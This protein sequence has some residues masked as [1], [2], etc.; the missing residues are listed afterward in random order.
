M[1]C[2]W[3]ASHSPRLQHVTAP[4]KADHGMGSIPCTT[5]I[6]RVCQISKSHRLPVART[7][8]KRLN[9][10]LALNMLAFPGGALQELV[11]RTFRT[12]ARPPQIAAGVNDSS[13]S[14]QAMYTPESLQARNTK[15]VQGSRWR[16][17]TARELEAQ[18]IVV[19]VTRLIITA[20]SHCTFSASV[21]CCLLNTGLTLGTY[22]GAMWAPCSLCLLSLAGRTI[23][24]DGMSMS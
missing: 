6:T 5:V 19:I 15:D 7:G 12:R 16:E 22:P 20:L 2:A 13:G 10:A 9:I 17:C 11:K 8:S 4:V 18:V 23:S 1:A 14:T 3:A 24:G 21:V